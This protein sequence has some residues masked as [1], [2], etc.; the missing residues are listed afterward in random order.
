MLRGRRLDT[1]LDDE[2]QFHLEMLTEDFMRR[3][4]SPADARAAALRSFGGVTQMKEEYREQRGLPF[5]EVLLQDVRYGVRALLRTKAFTAAAL[6]TLALGIGANSA[7]FSVVH[8]VL[9]RPL[10]YAE[11][12]RIV[13]LHRGSGGLW[14]GQSGRRYLFF[15]D[16]LKSVEALAA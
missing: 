11:P 3:G 6:V 13:Q 4:M 9:L 2:V 8:A 16:H 1:Q 14:A 10:D 15:R 12:E 7:I 5:I